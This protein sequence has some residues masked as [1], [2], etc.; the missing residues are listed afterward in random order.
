MPGFLGTFLNPIAIG[1]KPIDKEHLI[2]TINSNVLIVQRRTVKKF[3]NDKIFIENDSIIC[4]LD[5]VIFNNKFL[6]Q[7]YSVDSMSD[8]VAQLY[9]IYGETFFKYFRGSFCGLL[10]EKKEDRLVIFTDHIGD[11]PVFYSIIN[12]RL[13]FGTEIKYVTELLDQESIE[14]NLDIAGAYSSLTYGY[15]ISDLTYIEEIKRLCGGYYLYYDFKSGF[16]K[17]QYHQFNYKPNYS[18]SDQDIIN[19]ID[20]LFDKAIELQI[21][22][23]KE[24]NYSD[25]SS[26]SAGLDSRMTTYS[27]S[28]I[29]KSPFITFTYSPIDFYDQKTSFKIAKELNTKH[30][31]QTNNTGDLLTKIDESVALNEGLYM[32]FGSAV[33]KDYFDNLNLKEWGLIHSGQIG[34][35]IVGCFCGKPIDSNNEFKFVDMHS[36][37]YA[38]KFYNLFDFDSYVKNF[39][40]REIFSI[41]NRGFIGVGSGSNPVIH[42]YTETYSPFCDVDFCEFCL[43]IPIFKRK[44]KYIYD[45]WILQKYPEAS[46]YRHNGYRLIGRRRI[47][48]LINLSLHI[49]KRIKFLKHI[50]NTVTPL[51]LWIENKDIKL[52]LDDYFEENI[53]LLNAYPDLKRDSTNMYYDGNALEQ[54]QVLTLL[55]VIKL[56]FKKTP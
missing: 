54:N 37:R 19:R 49:T 32:Y 50:F 2:E 51:N 53:N 38:N 3:L 43:T 5:G 48:K 55:G 56:F 18:L 4:V 21:N 23:N 52:F 46:K 39:S 42:N 31:F 35:V 45:K 7:Q 25:I 11:K 9:Q 41:Y 20:E 14:F 28:K 40:D 13:Y 33:I 30:I 47:N 36:K 12:N 8:L 16:S 27:I 10:Y 29:K 22:K 44:N 34:D 26:L 24:Y 15:M 17:K 1:V 6:Y